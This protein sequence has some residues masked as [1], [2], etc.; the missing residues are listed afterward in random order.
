MDDRR[1]GRREQAGPVPALPSKPISTSLCWSN[2]ARISSS[3]QQAL[4]GTDDNHMR[5]RAAIDAYFA[6][7]DDKSAAFRLIFE[8]DLTNEP[9]GGHRGRHGFPLRHRGQPRDLRGYRAT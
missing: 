1:E 9:A 4:D 7:V 3:V 5:V 6:F 2:P 8:S